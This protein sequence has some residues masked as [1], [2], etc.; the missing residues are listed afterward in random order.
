MKNKPVK[1]GV[2]L[3]CICDSILGYTY[4]F[5]IYTGKETCQSSVAVTAATTTT[6]TAATTSAATTTPSA[7][8]DWK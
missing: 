3:Y 6:A 8:S 7:G 1:Q 5:E 2:K 4:N